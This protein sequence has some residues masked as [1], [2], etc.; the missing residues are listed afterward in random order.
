MPDMTIDYYIRENKRLSDKCNRQVDVLKRLTEQ[1]NAAC[2]QRDAKSNAFL[3]I[4]QVFYHVVEEALKE[5]LFY[6]PKRDTVNSRKYYIVE[7]KLFRALIKERSGEAD[8]K[9]ML[10]KW[11]NFG[12]VAK[13]A[14]DRFDGNYTVDMRAIRVIRVSKE[15]VDLL[16]EMAA[17][18]G[19]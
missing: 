19:Q 11:C 15:A 2:L 18:E 5:G 4:F 1:Q 13:F 12:L 8:A 14:N 17:K 16:R 9:R 10:E 3:F 6:E 7:A